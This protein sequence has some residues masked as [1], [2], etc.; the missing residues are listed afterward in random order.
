MA[1]QKDNMK[2]KLQSHPSRAMAE[3][4]MVRIR[5]AV[6]ILVDLIF[7]LVLQCDLSRTPI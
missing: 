7:L 3:K 2:E 5:T 6:I 1:I 4:V